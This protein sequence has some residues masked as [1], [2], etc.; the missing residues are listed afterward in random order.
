MSLELI[1]LSL[2]FI[3][4]HLKVEYFQRVRDFLR[5]AQFRLCFLSVI[6]FYLNKDYISLEIS[7]TI[8]NTSPPNWRLS[9]M[10]QP[11]LASQLPSVGCPSG[12]R[13]LQVEDPWPWVSSGPAC[14]QSLSLT[15]CSGS[16]PFKSSV[17]WNVR[18]IIQIYLHSYLRCLVNLKLT[19]IA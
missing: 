10:V 18:I 13:T 19:I 2:V 16:S 14:L 5:V 4:F 11:H 7:V 17:S 15:G 3:A 8:R 12:L 6:F 1:E 9:L